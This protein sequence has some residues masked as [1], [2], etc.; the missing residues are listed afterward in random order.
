LSSSLVEGD[1][2]GTAEAEIV[3]KRG[4]R[5]IDLTSVGG[6]T[7]LMREFVTLGEAR[8]AERMPLG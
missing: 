7:Q 2:A 5:A 4:P 8:S 3:L 6:A 1:D